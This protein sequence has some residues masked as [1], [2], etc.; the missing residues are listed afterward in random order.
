MKFSLFAL[1][2]L[3]I[4]AIAAPAAVDSTVEKRADNIEQEIAIVEAAYS[5]IRKYTGDIS[6]SRLAALGPSPFK[7]LTCPRRHRREHH[8][9][10]LRRRQGG[11]HQVRQR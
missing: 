4:G 5:T 11:R 3:F 10:L 9:F 1:P 8:A 6:M 7:T 2:A